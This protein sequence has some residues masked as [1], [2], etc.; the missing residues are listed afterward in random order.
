[1]K[2]KLTSQ[3]QKTLKNAGLSEHIRSIVNDDEDSNDDCYL[4]E[5]DQQRYQHVEGNEGDEDDENEYEN[6]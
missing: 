4:N 2:S 6:D 5:V 3:D 1:M